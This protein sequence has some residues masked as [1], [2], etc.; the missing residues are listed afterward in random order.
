MKENK[1]TKRKTWKNL[2]S[3]SFETTS[4]HKTKPIAIGKEVY[5]LKYDFSWFFQEKITVDASKLV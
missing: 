4:V 3:D 5:I 1:K 2:L